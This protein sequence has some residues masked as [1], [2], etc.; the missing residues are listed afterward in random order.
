MPRTTVKRNRCQA[1]V[2][3]AASKK[4]KYTAATKIGKNKRNIRNNQTII[5]TSHMH[6]KMEDAKHNWSREERK[7]IRM[8]K[9]TKIRKGLALREL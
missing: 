9:I 5:R 3:I 2:N 4:Q 7:H 1:A 8:V 6:T